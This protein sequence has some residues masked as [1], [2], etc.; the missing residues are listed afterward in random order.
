[1]HGR[2]RKMHKRKEEGRLL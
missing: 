2:K 1:M